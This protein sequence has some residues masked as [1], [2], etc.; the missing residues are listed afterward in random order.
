ML[1][2][3]QLTPE[4]DFS[5]Y[6][7]L[8]DL[9][10]DHF[11][12]CVELSIRLVR[13]VCPGKARTLGQKLF[14]DAMEYCA[15]RLPRGAV[16]GELIAGIEPSRTRSQA[17]SASLRSARFRP[18]ASSVRQSAPA[19]PTGR[20]RRTKTC[21]SSW[22]R[23]TTRA[24]VTGFRSASRR[25]SRSAWSSPR[26][27]PHFWRREPPD[28]YAYEAWRRALRVAA[29]PVFHYRMR[30]AARRASGGRAGRDMDPHMQPRIHPILPPG[31]R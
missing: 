21:A 5:R 12:F 9:G 20:R 19:W 14:F 23:C 26:T 17:S 18:S 31:R 25:T 11:S 22:R 3:V 16:S 7:R 28:F 6:D 4:R 2:G 13:A 27:M 15:A 10:V 24:A 1:V 30:T 8:I 29:K